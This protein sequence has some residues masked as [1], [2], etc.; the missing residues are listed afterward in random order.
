VNAQPR[1]DPFVQRLAD[2]LDQ[3]AEQAGTP[4][5]A[6]STA[7]DTTDDANRVT[8]VVAQLRVSSTW[9]EPPADL[10]ATVLARVLADAGRAAPAEADSAPIADS[11]PEPIAEEA[12]EPVGEPVAEAEVDAPPIAGELH[13]T[14]VDGGK[15]VAPQAEAEPEVQLPRSAERRARLR[16]AIPVAAVAA[17]T[18]TF[19][20]LVV[21]RALEGGPA[22]GLTYVASGTSLA[23]EA[24][25]TVSVASSGAGFSVVLDAHDLPAAALG[26]YYIAWLRG[27]RGTVPIGSL[28]ARK[29]GKPITMWS[30]VDPAAYSTFLLTLQKEGE[31]VTPSRFVVLTASLHR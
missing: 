9:I 5:A 25:A 18:L 19:S 31:P 8:A 3:L 21:E 15:S 1:D 14:A 30:G 17:V 10:R 16:W 28:H 11:G 4:D 29:I 13:L 22:K 6:V 12:T 24:G 20:V 2:R 27:P 23:P 7:V 26:S